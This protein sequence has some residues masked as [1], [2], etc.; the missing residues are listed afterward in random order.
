MLDSP[1]WMSGPFKSL[2]LA[3]LPDCAI[4]NL[5]ITD[6]HDVYCT[7][8]MTGTGQCIVPEVS[9]SE[10]SLWPSGRRMVPLQDL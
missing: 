2:S 6:F 1:E 3:T 8:L 10:A 5:R 9:T 7:R 4:L